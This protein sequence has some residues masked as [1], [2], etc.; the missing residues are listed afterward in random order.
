MNMRNIRFVTLFFVLTLVVG[1]LLLAGTP[2][3][4]A[5]RAPVIAFIDFDRAGQEFNELKELMQEYQADA[6]YY[7]SLLKPLEDELVQLQKQSTTSNTFQMKLNEYQLQ[8]Q[9]YLN[10]IESKYNPRVE[11]LQQK[12]MDYAKEYA[13]INGIDILLTKA[14][15]MYVNDMYD[16]T[17]NFIQYVN[18]NY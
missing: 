7:N 12:L 10:Q 18:T 13:K 4:A 8:Q 3:T 5:S 11:S 14:V 17:T 15:S 2:F 6:E 16:V 9:K 1:T